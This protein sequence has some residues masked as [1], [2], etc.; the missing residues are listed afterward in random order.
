MILLKPPVDP[1]DLYNDS[2][3]F[4]ETILSMMFYTEKI[5]DRIEKLARVGYWYLDLKTR[6]TVWSKGTYHIY[7]LDPNQPSPDSETYFAKH[8]HPEDRDYIDAQIKKCIECGHAEF[9]QRIF[10]ADGE[11]RHIISNIEPVYAGGELA[12]VSGTALDVTPLREAECETRKLNDNLN[13]IVASLDDSVFQLDLDL[14]FVNVWASDPARLFFKKE[15]FIGKNL[16]VVFPEEFGA[17]ISAKIKGVIKSGVGESVSYQPPYDK[18]HYVAKIRKV[19]AADG[20]F[21]IVSVK[22]VEDKYQLEKKLALNEERWAFA[23]ENANQGVWDWDIKNNKMFYSDAWKT[24][25]GYEP[26]EIRNDLT[27]WEKRV[28]PDDL[29]KAY[30]DVKLHIDGKTDFYYNEHRML[31]KSGEYIW[32]IDRGKIVER[33]ATG[34]PT[35]FVGTHT[36]ITKLKAAEGRIEEFKKL[37]DHSLDP[38]G[39]A[40]L[41]GYFVQVNPAMLRVF[42]YSEKELQSTPFMD[43][44]HPDDR[45]DSLAEMQAFARGEKQAVEYENR[46]LCKDGSIR[47]VRWSISVDLTTGRLY[48]TGK[49]VTSER[50]AEERLQRSETM[51]RKAQE[52]AKIGHW[53]YDIKTQNLEWSDETRRIHEVE[54][55]YTPDVSRALDFY[56][57]DS[58]DIIE[59]TFL[60]TVRHGGEYDLSLQIITAKGNVKDVRAIGRAE[61]END[62][63][64]AVSG[65]FQDISQQK[66]AERLLKASEA[67]LN[68]AQLIAGIG[69][70][71]YL[72]R[73]KQT[74][75]SKA[76]YKI[77]EWPEGTADAEKYFESIHP[78]DLPRLK[79]FFHDALTNKKDYAIQ[80]RII[81]P[82]GKIKYVHAIA[83]AIIGEDGEVEAL[84][85]TAQDITEKVNHE[86]QLIEAKERAEKASQAKAE[87]LSMMSHEI[88]TPLNAVIGTTHLLLQENP[89]GDQ[90]ENLRTMKFSA[91]NLLSLI[92]DILDFSK[93]ESGKIEFEEMPF[94]IRHL[95]NG[96]LSAS[97][98]KANEKS[99][100][101][102]E[103]IDSEIPDVLL[104]D[105]T[106]LGQ[107]L[108]N[109]VNNAVKF[110]EKG[111][112][113]LRIK[114]EP[115]TDHTIALLFEVSDTGIG[116]S[117]K[118][119]KRIFDVFTQERSDTS[120]LFG[121]SGLGLTITKNLLQLRNSKIELKS[122]KG[123]G[124]RFYFR[125]VFKLPGQTVIVVDERDL[126][127]SAEFKSL[128]GIKVLLAEDNPINIRIG[129]KFLK[130]LQ[131]EI[132]VAENG[133]EAV[134]KVM[135][136]DYDLVLMDL[137]MPEM[138]GL[139]AT[140][141]IRALENPEK[142][143][144]PIVALTASAL[145]ETKNEVEQAGMDGYLTKPFNPDDFF[146]KVITLVRK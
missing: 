72:P 141:K 28:H 137:Q 32:I 91:V 57:L 1:A 26:H 46:C 74:R 113:C 85:G 77:W 134:R 78:K 89:R 36:D 86:K 31:H 127:T 125:L 81:T 27:E 8:A 111:H 76:L 120:R 53:Q 69:S 34:Q 12:G 68:E 139:A 92:N 84:R 13:A 45:A 44:V 4:I 58:R 71:E 66:S 93:I 5:L 47:F 95:A 146:R 136:N 39:I 54:P 102:R 75:W 135:E 108:N 101:L 142:A 103:E 29:E 30:D 64:V 59:K 118:N 83:H 144:T 20:E 97:R 82:R 133:A 33:T 112:V 116:I 70:W 42:G 119:Q 17:F 104:G 43:L 145:M 106:R 50:L 65:V 80:H 140:R 117:K 87:F 3:I 6:E 7:R 35:R 14:N 123:K 2:V 38:A 19:R 88:R 10:R 126:Q 96:I 15:E 24:M 105:S 23:L 107:I 18:C 131:V 121:G 129:T 52:T 55:D 56:Y 41:D 51:F 138:D 130:K 98:L 40:T 21:I 132:D 62:E 128:K 114:R 9:E 99:I 110:T 124:S 67:K 115:E 100:T 90:L 94:S 49:D 37:Y 22:D 79:K 122:T 109:L 143:K 73:E 63:I 60:D 48:G 16:A 25:L 61:L 11:F